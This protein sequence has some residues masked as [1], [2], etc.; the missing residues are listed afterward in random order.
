LKHLIKNKDN[1]KNINY[2]KTKENFTKIEAILFLIAQRRFGHGVTVTDSFEIASDIILEFCWD[3]VI[4]SFVEKEDINNNNNKSVDSFLKYVKKE[5]AGEKNDFY[6]TAKDKIVLL[7]LS[8][9]ELEKN[10]IENIQAIS[11]KKKDT[12]G[13]TSKLNAIQFLLALPRFGEY[14]GITNSLEFNHEMIDRYT[15]LDKKKYKAQNIN[16]DTSDIIDKKTSSKIQKRCNDILILL[17]NSD[18]IEAF[19]TRGLINI[20]DT[21]LNQL[22]KHREIFSLKWENHIESFSP[23]E[24]TDRKR[25][26]HLSVFCLLY[27]FEYSAEKYKKNQTEILSKYPPTEAEFNN[28]ILRQLYIYQFMSE[29][30]GLGVEN[31][32]KCLDSLKAAIKKVNTIYEEKNNY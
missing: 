4:T 14:E 21:N 19:K 12:E 16:F 10:N 32:D 29:I 26:I 24:I 28:P 25:M 20:T 17:E 11:P 7:M 18:F 5:F 8:K 13:V 31:I 15:G 22:Q 30:P 1:I 2:L 9:K 6:L 23:Q 27:I 3:E